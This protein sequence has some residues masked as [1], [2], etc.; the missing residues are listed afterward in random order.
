MHVNIAHPSILSAV[1]KLMAERDVV[2][3]ALIA[4]VPYSFIPW[5]LVRCAILTHRVIRDHI[6]VLT[7]CPISTFFRRPRTH[8]C[9]YRRRSV[10]SPFSTRASAATII[11][12]HSSRLHA[13]SV[14][15]M[16]ANPPALN[17]DHGATR[18]ATR[19]DRSP[20]TYRP[21]TPP[22]STGSDAKYSADYLWL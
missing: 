13:V 17:A 9:G 11:A 1:W 16:A 19:F 5:F 6:A 12:R 2:A 8:S 20:A 18:T 15:V 22:P 7:L 3:T 21:L 14:A 4:L 10:S